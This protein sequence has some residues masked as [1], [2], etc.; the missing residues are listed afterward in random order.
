MK[1][2]TLLGSAFALA[3]SIAITL[4]GVARADLISPP[5]PE[6][7]DRPAGAQCILDNGTAGTCV[8]HTDPR[9]PGRTNISCEP[10]A[11]ECDRLAVGAECHGYLHRPSHCR[12]FTNDRNEH[13]RACMNDET[14]ASASPNGA[15]TPTAQPTPANQVVAPTTRPASAGRQCN[16]RPGSAPRERPALAG[17]ALAVLAGFTVTRL[18]RAR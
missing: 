9:R 17:V 12:E 8:H 10:D 6:C 3:F 2:T 5:P 16:T 15:A 18:R 13:W 14:A 1:H 11:H 4:P 7:V